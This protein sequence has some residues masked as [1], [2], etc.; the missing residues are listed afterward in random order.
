MM[1]CEQNNPTN[2]THKRERKR[3]EAIAKTSTLMYLCSDTK[4]LYGIVMSTLC[5][6][7]SI[8]TSYNNN[9]IINNNNENETIVLETR[10]YT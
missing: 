8:I 1:R 4:L 10:L 9:N 6:N 7:E 3:N 2:D 5:F